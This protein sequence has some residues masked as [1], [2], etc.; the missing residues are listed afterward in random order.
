MTDHDEIRRLLADYC[1]GTDSG[2][3]DRWTAC[4]T[5]DVVW[6]GGAFGRFEGTAAA[7]AY[8][9]AAGDAVSAFRHVNTNLLIDVAG[10]S[11]TVDSYVQVYDQSGPTPAII[12]SGF[13]RDALVKRAGRWLIRTR[14]L[15]ADPAVVA[16]RTGLADRLTHAATPT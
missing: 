4:F 12:F 1:F 7:R 6:E 10:D 3:T 16:A 15:I 14:D 11:A 13:Y 8:H 5:N 9:V 2:D